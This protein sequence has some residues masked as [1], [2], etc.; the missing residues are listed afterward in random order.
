MREAQMWKMSSLGRLHALWILLA[1]VRDPRTLRKMWQARGENFALFGGEA[2]CSF[3]NVKGLMAQEPEKLPG[4]YAPMDD[5]ETFFSQGYMPFMQKSPNH[6][7]RRAYVFERVDAARARL[8]VLEGLLGA[9]PSPEH[10]IAHFLLL[11]LGGIEPTA[12]EVDD[13]VFFRKNGPILAFFP[14]WMRDTVFKAKY[15]RAIAVRKRLLDRFT[16]AGN[17]FPDTC[18]EAI[19]FNAGTLGF[20]PEK[21]LAAVRADAALMAEIAPEIDAPPQARPKMRALIMEMLR[22]H[23]RIASVNYLVDGKPKIALIATAVMDP[24]RFPDPEKVDLTR[25]HSDSVSFALPSP[26]RSCPGKDLAPEVMAAV[27]AHLLGR[28]AARLEEVA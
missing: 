18:M 6:S 24:A 20:Y 19:W 13:M 8:D 11:T 27:L 16:A 17:P 21:A 10:A 2:V 22:L 3:A 26:N 12:Q 28:K 14:R 23:S 9:A 15:Q 1:H 4:I 7:A 25:D 5:E